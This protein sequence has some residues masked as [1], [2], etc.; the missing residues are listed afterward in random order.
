MRTAFLAFL[1]LNLA[2]EAYAQDVRDIRS[3]QIRSPHISFT[4]GG[5]IPRADLNERYG[6]FGMMLANFAV[7]EENN[8]YWGIRCGLI[9]GSFNITDEPGFLSNLFTDQGT[10]IDNEG[11]VAKIKVSGRGGLYGI[12]LGKIFHQAISFFKS[13]KNSGLF[14]RA[15]LGLIHHKI[16]MDFT[17]NKITQLEDPYVKGYDRFCLGYFSSVF[18]GYW[19][20]STNKQFNYFFGANF[21]AGQTYPMRTTNFDTGIPDED[22]RFDAGFGLEFGW[23][24]HLY[25]QTHNQNW[26]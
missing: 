21:L 3:D 14:L 6:L 18:L 16:R 26:H 8:F 10:I 12:Q 5:L 13:N 22:A 7:K 1:M 4:M 19:H 24:F 2:S 20:M 15:D 11:D 9:N 17:E 23:V 25:K